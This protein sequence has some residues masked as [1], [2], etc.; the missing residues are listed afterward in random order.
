[1]S[2]TL[3]QPVGQKRLTNVAVVRLKKHGNRFEIACYKNKVLSWRSH[4]YVWVIMCCACFF[5][6]M[7]FGVDR[8]FRL[9]IS[10][11]LLR[12]VNWTDQICVS[13]PQYNKLNMSWNNEQGEV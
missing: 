1:M 5:I 2:K 11:A 3:V 12:D 13:F 4:V 7:L 9:V 8:E 10:I 6:L